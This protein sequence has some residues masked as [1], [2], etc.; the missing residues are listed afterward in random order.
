MVPL[1]VANGEIKP[2]GEVDLAQSMRLWKWAELSPVTAG[3]SSLT[4]Q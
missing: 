4:D 3:F 1:S 2:A